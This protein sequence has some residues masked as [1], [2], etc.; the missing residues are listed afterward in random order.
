MSLEDRESA[1]RKW[2]GEKELNISM[3]AASFHWR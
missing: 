1:V 3:S 2:G